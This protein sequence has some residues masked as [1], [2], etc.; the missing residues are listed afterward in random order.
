MTR[1][2]QLFE[3]TRSEGRPALIPYLT[4]GDPSPAAWS[5]FDELFRAV[6]QIEPDTP[7]RAAQ[8]PG[9]WGKT[10]AMAEY[11]QE[12]LQSSRAIMPPTLWLVVLSGTFL[13]MVTIFVL[14]HSR[15]NAVMIML[16]SSSFGLV[17]MFLI[18]MEHPFAGGENIDSTPF[19]NAIANI[20]RWD[21]ETAT[22]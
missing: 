8:L 18:A 13:I 11:R 14:P 3:R 15:F 21:R 22:K 7:R 6:A 17:F 12:R 4:A 9:I 2:G 5:K 10:N 1:I 20:E 16:V 19:A